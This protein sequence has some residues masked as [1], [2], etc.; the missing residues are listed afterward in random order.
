[1]PLIIFCT[2][3]LEKAIAYLV[4]FREYLHQ[5]I[6]LFLAIFR[7]NTT[8]KKSMV[9]VYLPKAID[10]PIHCILDNTNITLRFY[11]DEGLIDP[12]RIVQLL[13]LLQKF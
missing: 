8:T 7:K 2:K 13:D 10:S 1:M 12:Y 11:I 3:N 9:L 5:A 4:F 6:P